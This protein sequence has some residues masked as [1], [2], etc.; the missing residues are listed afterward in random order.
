MNVRYLVYMYAV[1]M[2]G[3]PNDGL[4]GE[5]YELVVMLLLVLCW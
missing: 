3:N 1:V 4:E 2:N 5:N